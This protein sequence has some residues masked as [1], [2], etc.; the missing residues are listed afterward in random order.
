MPSP[1]G[2]IINGIG[3]A[4]AN[5]RLL[6]C[7]VLLLSGACANGPASQEG[8]QPNENA[9]RAVL[10][11]APKLNQT[12]QA[13]LDLG[14]AMLLRGSFQEAQ[15]FY[16]RALESAENPLG[17]AR[18][19]L[20][21]VRV[22]LAQGNLK[23]AKDWLKHA[24]AMEQGGAEA[25][26]ADWLEAKIMSREGDR[27]GAAEALRR[28]T[29]RP[30]LGVRLD[31][32]AKAADYL[33]SE[34]G[35]HRGEQA[36]LG[37]LLYSARRP[38]SL[39]SRDLPPWIALTAS[40][41]PASQLAELVKVEPDQALQA[42]LIAG[43][44]RSYLQAG[45]TAG[46]KQATNY[47]AALKQGGRWRPWIEAVR[48]DLSR[49][50]MV[51]HRSVGVVLPLSGPQAE[52]GRRALLAIKL[53]LGVIQAPD[54]ALALYAMDSQAQP[55]AAERAVTELVER[56]HV[57]MII[58]PLDAMAALAAARRAQALET[59][60]I[61]LSGDPELAKAGSFVFRNYPTPQDQVA[62]IMP[63][64]LEEGSSLV[65][66][67]A[68]DDKQSREFVRSLQAWL[69]ARTTSQGKVRT[70]VAGRGIRLL[71]PEFYSPGG[72]AWL[73]GL[74]KLVRLPAGGRGQAGTGGRGPVI[75]F[76][77]LWLPG[78]R[79]DV[80]R[81]VPRLSNY[82]VRGKQLLGTL[83]WHNR[84]LLSAVGKLLEGA[85]FSDAFDPASGREQVRGF[86]QSFQQ[87]SAHE[88]GLLEALAHDSAL[89]VRNILERAQ[90]TSNRQELRLAL[91]KVS[92]VDGVCGKL[93]MGPD[94]RLRAPMKLFRVQQGEFQS[95]G[96]AP[97][98]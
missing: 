2:K 91:S 24:A 30:M 56:H 37:T 60:I 73:T 52:K 48:Q 80:E 88:P 20:G 95:M 26:Q 11:A 97:L 76:D 59:P 34:L 5:W 62:A 41:I 79:E 35:L 12:V 16:K 69:A 6:V 9:P 14:Q 32:Q 50:P 78:P 25:L 63:R 61:C 46:A 31:E 70:L 81:L 3:A 21:L 87:E 23:Q 19:T 93:L 22:D 45:D 74:D 10:P 38:G 98:D 27:P 75:N 29:A 71:P 40:R 85:L 1:Y 4:L 18:A 28:F 72:G 43:L 54:K 8:A 44:S 90:A 39:A 55:M 92:G 84:K 53:A 42:A 77:R 66:M 49:G 36:L 17:E 96:P 65:A 58:G 13:S 86:R 15:V 89:V 83:G 33:A 82:G 51:E 68:P 94:R 67:L 47:L 64:V 57:A 7:C